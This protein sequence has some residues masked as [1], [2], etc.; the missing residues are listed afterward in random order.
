[1]QNLQFL[2]LSAI[3]FASITTD[4][5]SNETVEDPEAIITTASLDDSASDDNTKMQNLYNRYTRALNSLISS[6]GSSSDV[7]ATNTGNSL[8]AVSISNYQLGLLAS[9]IASY[10]RPKKVDVSD[11][12]EE[13]RP[14]YH[15]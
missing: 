13:W 9:N 2:N 1:M 4:E 14:E 7:T 8:N 12:P 6:I 11:L 15:A 5:R 3:D 10:Q